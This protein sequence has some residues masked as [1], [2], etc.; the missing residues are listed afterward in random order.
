[1]NHAEYIGRLTTDGGV[2]YSTS[3]T[4]F[5]R[6]SIAV[7]REFKRDGEPDAD[8]FDFV[9]FGKGAETFEK[10]THKGSK[11][12]LSGRNQN[13]EYTNKDGQKV[14]NNRLIVEKFEFLD[15]KSNAEP[16]EEKKTDGRPRQ[17][18]DDFLNVPDGLIDELPFN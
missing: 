13:T 7:D 5:Y 15:G 1:M 6:N 17:S 9:L 16:K 12:F 18:L 10:W 4:A 8:F 2:S 14:R 3:G 11:V